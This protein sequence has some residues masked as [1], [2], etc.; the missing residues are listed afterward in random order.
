MRPG[1]LVL[2]LLATGA[3][4]AGTA[5]AATPSLTVSP[6]RVHQGGKVTFTGSGWAHKVKVTLLLGKPG[7]AANPFASVTTNGRGR[8]SYT[9]PIKPTAPTGKYVIHACRKSCA[10]DVKRNMTIAP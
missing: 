1:K 6:S 4:A 5:F 7:T 3:V 8:F 10:T 2:A 9:L